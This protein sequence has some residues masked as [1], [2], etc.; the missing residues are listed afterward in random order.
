MTEQP[1][2]SPQAISQ[3]QSELHGL[4]QSLR[5]ARHLGP[6]AQRSLAD[7]LDELRNELHSPAL[8]SAQAAHLAGLVTQLA[9]ALHEQRDQGPIDA[10]RTRLQESLGRA[11]AEAPVLGGVVRR[12]V[13]TLA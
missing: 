2:T 9:R 8:D 7:L 6:D 4:A 3:I 10:L 11:E 5:E 1:G 12:F 13:D